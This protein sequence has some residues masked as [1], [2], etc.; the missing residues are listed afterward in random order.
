MTSVRD[1]PYEDIK[2]FLNANGKKY[3]DRDEAYDFAF[4][5]FNNRK[6]KGHTTSIIEWMMAHNLL[7][8]NAKIPMYTIYDI[9]NMPQEE[10]NDLAKL[11]T[12][13]R[14]N[15]TNI[16]NILRYLHKL[17][18]KIIINP[19]I[20]SL[21]FPMLDELELKEIDLAELR[22]DDVIKLLKTH[23]NKKLI[24]EF[25]N[26]NLDKI[27][28]YNTYYFDFDYEG[29]HNDFMIPEINIYNKDII[30]K[31]ILDNKEK[32]IKSISDKELNNLIKEIKENNE[33]EGGEIYTGKLEMNRLIKFTFDLFEINEINLAKRVFDVA[34][35]LHLY[36]RSY[37]YNVEL[38]D[39]MLNTE[40]IITVIDWMGDDEFLKSFD[41][42]E[43][44]HYNY[45][46]S[47]KD[48]K[49][50]IEKLIKLD[51][52]DLSV[53]V[54][55]LYIDKFEETRIYGNSEI[56]EILTEHLAELRKYDL[57]IEVFEHYLNLLSFHKKKRLAK[58]LDKIKKAISNNDHDLVLQYIQENE[59]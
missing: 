59:L 52:Y 30:V 25:I 26:K 6:A 4:D 45:D 36:G 14:N 8:N 17:N 32:L 28:I 10:I 2:V 24:R 37:S 40:N 57:L 55:E 39:N 31:I 56:F 20:S 47:D 21:I 27:I 23:R 15:R 5:L 3:K 41:E 46:E 44:S 35:K 9:D 34:N 13:K 16:K 43:I 42:L 7:Q 38:I 49:N 48:I 22:Y 51:R 1:V 53:K 12:M 19:D 11:L 33:D 50:L 18:E 29:E 54:F 58:I